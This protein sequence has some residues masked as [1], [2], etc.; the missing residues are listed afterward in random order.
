M[1]GP[2]GTT[3]RPA[4]GPSSSALTSSPGSTPT[5]STASLSLSLTSCLAHVY[6]NFKCDMNEGG[7]TGV[8]TAGGEEQVSLPL[9]GLP[10]LV[11]PHLSAAFFLL[12]LVSYPFPSPIP[13]S[14]SPFTFTTAS[15]SIMF[16]PRVTLLI[17]SPS[18]VSHPCNTSSCPPPAVSTSCVTSL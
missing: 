3:P 6:F 5:V 4:P 7:T 1:G 15:S 16:P 10:S 18:F 2:A 11:T 8:D 12:S 17:V 13:V 9:A 14:P